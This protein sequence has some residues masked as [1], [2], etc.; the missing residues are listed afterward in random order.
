MLKANNV[1]RRLVALVCALAA[2]G[3]GN[4]TEPQPAPAARQTQSQRARRDVDSGMFAKVP[5]PVDPATLVGKRFDSTSSALASRAA[6]DAV[7]NKS[8]NEAAA[9]AA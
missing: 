7:A 4:E 6:P 8:A 2:I 1:C 9:T 5:E 3:C